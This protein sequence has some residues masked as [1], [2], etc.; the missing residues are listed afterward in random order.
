MTAPGEAGPTS[1]Q[2]IH[3]TFSRRLP[4]HALE[5][6]L[7]KDLGF[8]GRRGQHGSLK[9]HDTKMKDSVECLGLL[10][11]CHGQMARTNIK[12]AI[13]TLDHTARIAI[14]PPVGNAVAP[15]RFLFHPR[16]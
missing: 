3:L 12:M 8:L 13:H 5:R 16:S 1:V 6:I 14:Q 11:A 9:G 10:Y 7:N 2:G 4:L 15:Q